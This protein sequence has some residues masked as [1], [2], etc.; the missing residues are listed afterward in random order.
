MGTMEPGILDPAS[1]PML[2]GQQ[3]TI[4]DGQNPP[5]QLLSNGQASFIARNS[6]SLIPFLLIGKA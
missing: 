1:L 2:L 6:L 3:L 4:T 5:P